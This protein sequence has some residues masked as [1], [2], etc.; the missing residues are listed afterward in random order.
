MNPQILEIKQ[1]EITKL[2]LGCGK[3]QMEDYL[4]V[5]FIDLG[6]DMVVDLNKL[7][8][9]FDENC[10]EEIVIRQTLGHL[11]SENNYQVRFLTDVHRVCKP[12]RIIKLN[13][14]YKD[15][16]RNIQ[17]TKGYDI[18]ALMRLYDINEDTKES[19][20]FKKKLF[21]LSGIIK[22]QPTRIGKYV[23]NF[24]FI[25]GR[26]HHYTFREVLALFFPCLIHNLT[27]ELE[28]VK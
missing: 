11:N 25:R 27:V 9:P 8:L 24:K 14:N 17:H 15:A 16:D 4:N 3:F 22:N 20:L 26:G 12:N 7:P 1:K 23:P 18:N 28:V 21:K 2:N 5:D 19:V 10:F 13:V 6:Q